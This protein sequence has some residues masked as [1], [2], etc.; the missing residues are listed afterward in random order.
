LAATPG[1]LLRP[2]RRDDRFLAGLHDAGVP[3]ATATVRLTALHQTQ[4]IVP[5]AVIA[6]GA[7]SPS[8]VTI[9]MTSF[10][11][12]HPSARFVVDPAVCADVHTRV[13]PELPGLIRMIVTPDRPVTGLDTAL[14]AVGRRPDEIDF[15]LPTHLHWDHISGLVELPA[16]VPV[17]TLPVERDF[18]L[19]GSGFATGPLLGRTFDTYELDGPPVLTFDRSHDLFGDGSVVLV[20]LAGHT[21]GSVGVLLA[22][23]GGHRVLLAGDAVWHGLQVRLLREKAPF[24]GNLVDAD[25]DAAF[26]VVHRLHALPDNIEVIASHDK[27]VT[28]RWRAT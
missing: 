25:R 23:Q 28:D 11:V 10:L 24:P 7:R 2:R 14:A 4:H 9:G 21:P 3:E 19:G 1:R 5:T 22:V 27:S 20:D 26:A 8:R 15:A 6:E 18:I 13:L 16:A 12:E 17:R